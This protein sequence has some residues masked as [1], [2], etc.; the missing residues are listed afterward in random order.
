LDASGGT[1]RYSWSFGNNAAGSVPPGLS[2][3]TDGTLA[4]TPTQY[5]PLSAQYNTF[6]VVV[7]DSATPKQTAPATLSILVA[8]TLKIETTALPTATVGVTTDVPLTASGGIPP[9]TW[10]ATVL[11][12]PNIGVQLVNGNVLEY[13]PTAA[14]NSI[15]TLTVKDSEN[16]PDSTQTNLPLTIVPLQL[17]TTTA[18]TSSNSTAGTGQSIVLTAKVTQPQGGV[19]PA[20]QVTFFNGTVIVGTAMLGADATATLQTSFANAG[21]YSLIASYGG[22]AIYAPSAST[23]L[24]ETVVTPTVNGS[25]SPSSITIQS[26]NTGQLIITI[27]PVGGYAGTINFSCGTLPPEVSCAFSP[28]SLTIPTN[29]G[30]M[31]DT[32]TVSTGA[33]HVA[34]AVE[35]FSGRGP[36]HVGIFSAATFW[37]PGSLGLLLTMVSRKRRVFI[38][39]RRNRWLVAT[40]GILCAMGLASCGGST[41]NKAAPST[42]QISV[43]LTVQGQA[44]QSIIATIIVQ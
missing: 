18:L 38:P 23:P 7:S 16:I 14:T 1:P 39:Q 32:L 28:Q 20:G 27:T 31:T 13:N 40:L 37:L 44:A 35:P 9:Y 4:G 10:S 11:P 2:L 36:M 26:G 43:S 33:T 15:V 12:N 42:Y 17:A 3:T 21:V 30:P 22:N 25:I 8:R 6:N 19:P 29:S 5:T 41:A 24:T 34:T